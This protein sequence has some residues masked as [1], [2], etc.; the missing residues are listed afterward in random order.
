[1]KTQEP[2][3]LNNPTITQFIQVLQEGKASIK[4]ASEMLCQIADLNPN[5]Y[6]DI[7]KICPEISSNLLANLEKV[8]RGVMHESLLYDTS[9]AARRIALL[10]CSQ[11]K[12]VC[13]GTVK[14]VTIANGK[15]IVEEKTASQLTKQ[16]VATVFSEHN[17]IRTVE[18]QI[19]ELSKPK[20]QQAKLAQRYSIN[21]S[22]VMMLANTFFT[23]AQLEE[24]LE[25]L[26]RNSIEELKRKHK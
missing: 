4:R 25:T 26:K 1:M 8:G 16:E 2:A 12:Q 15:N 11:Q 17:Q 6:R 24:I 9:P 22:T 7:A 13:E 10:P 20:V 3:I 5:A 21:G 18:E 19:K 14:V 23:A